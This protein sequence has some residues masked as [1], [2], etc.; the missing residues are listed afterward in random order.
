MAAFHYGY[1]ILKIPA[2]NGAIIIHTDCKAASILQDLAHVFDKLRSTL[3]MLNYEKCV[4]GVFVE[5]LLD[6]LI[7]HRGI[8]ANPEKIRAIENMRP[9]AGIKDVQKLTGCP[10]ALSRFISKLG[11]RALPFFK[12]L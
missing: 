7:S 5:K 10:A 9:P 12:L 8:K 6:F 11:E 4:F 2:P 1:L 3:T